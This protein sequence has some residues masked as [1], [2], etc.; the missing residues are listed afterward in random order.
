MA[1][2]NFLSSP[3]EMG[4]EHLKLVMQLPENHVVRAYDAGVIGPD[5]RK[6]LIK[7]NIDSQNMTQ[8]IHIVDVE[9]RVRVG[10]GVIDKDVDLSERPNAGDLRHRAVSAA[11]IFDTMNLIIEAHNADSGKS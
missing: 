4:P 11:A 3:D 7:G 8:G 6:Y 1:G 10:E 5:G 2:G 9:G